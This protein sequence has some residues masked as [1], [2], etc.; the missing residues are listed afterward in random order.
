MSH[1]S[2]IMD[3][4]PAL[5][6]S[7]CFLLILQFL[8]SVWRQKKRSCSLPPGPAP[9]PLLGNYT[10]KASAS[11]HYP[12]LYKKYGPVFTVWHL[13][14]PTVVIC[15]YKVV[16]DAL[17]D[18]AEQFSGRPFLPVISFST[19]GYGFMT[20][21]GQL[22]RHLRRLMLT[23]LRN[24]GMGKQSLNKRVLEE[25]ELLLQAVSETAGK[26]FNPLQAVGYA[27]Y[28]ITSSI[29]FGKCWKYH[30]Q[31][32][33]E[34]ITTIKKQFPVTQSSLCQ[35]CN[36]FPILL[37]LPAIRGKIF[38]ET[39][40]IQSFVKKQIDLHKQT[41]DE[42]SPRDFI[43]FFLL[44]IKEEA[45][46]VDTNLSD[47]GL[48]MTASTLFMGNDSTSNNLKFILVAMAHFP[49][50][51]AQV[52]QEIDKVTGS[53][54]P[55]GSMD[56]PQLPYTIA[57]VQEAMR[58]AD[59]TS[60]GLDH[61]L[62]EDTHFQGFI[63]PKGTTVTPFF[64]SVMSDPT[65]WETP[66]DFNPGHFLDDKG[67]IRARPAFMPFSAG[68]RACPGESLA[69]TSILLLFCSLLQR[70]TFSRAPGTRPQTAKSLRDNK[71]THIM[72]SELCAVPRTISCN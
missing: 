68:K 41:L 19:K 70:F 9:L 56:K 30:D 10:S 18:H 62:T 61:A 21:N 59:L 43:D 57:V 45:Q 47:T 31:E 40:F 6:L 52:Q 66:D 26:A 33:H 36:V 38:K 23:I 64:T 3:A 63:I 60:T 65:E 27:V 14:E 22:W 34:L 54:R 71:W 1:G 17:I 42:R 5:A 67:Q 35:L 58:L 32:L 51:Q 28:N 7:S 48:Q 20:D 15:G 25:A 37:R 4:F 2:M 29:L 24:C 55:V 72:F 13:T 16:K 39:W 50:I 11:K 46:T 44:K 49:D 8:T 53:H 12:E 69:R